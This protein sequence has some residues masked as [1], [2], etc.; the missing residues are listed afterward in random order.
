M[1]GTI[2]KAHSKARSLA[3]GGRHAERE[4]MNTRHTLRV[5]TAAKRSRNS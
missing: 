3:M 5:Q 2:I 1:S 4:T